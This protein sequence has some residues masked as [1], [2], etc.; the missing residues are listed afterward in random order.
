MKELV[1]FSPQK[2]FGE[3]SWKELITLNAFALLI[4]E[5]ADLML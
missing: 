4:K 3:V 1:E 2:G 5:K